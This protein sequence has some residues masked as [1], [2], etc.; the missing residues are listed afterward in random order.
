MN[1]GCVER[2][3]LKEGAGTG[4]CWRRRW[5]GMSMRSAQPGKSLTLHPPVTTLTAWWRSP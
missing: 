5:S 3:T 4:R 1:Q 2:P